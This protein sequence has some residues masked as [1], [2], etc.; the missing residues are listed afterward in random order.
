M[1]ADTASVWG[2]KSS[3]FTDTRLEDPA[4]LK[5]RAQMVLEGYKNPYVTYKASAVDLFRLTGMTWDKYMPGKL[6]DVM[7]AEHGVQLRSRIVSISKGDTRAIRGR[8][9]S[10]LPTPSAT[11]RTAST[12]W[13]IG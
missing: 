6:V 10:R 9:K 12:P 8:L 11:R 3:V 1:D 5:A 13:R 4:Q 7:D 2:I